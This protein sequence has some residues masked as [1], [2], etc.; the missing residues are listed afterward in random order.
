MV[1]CEVGRWSA[2][3]DSG[4]KRGLYRFAPLDRIRLGHARPRW[5]IGSS[6]APVRYDAASIAREQRGNK[7]GTAGFL[8]RAYDPYYLFPSGG[9]MD[10]NKMEEINVDDLQLRPEVSNSRLQRR[11]RLRDL[12][13]QQM[14]HIDKAVEQYDLNSY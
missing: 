12:L 1:L 10:M 4:G 2:F 3:I 11:A 9:D 7:A 5:E 14:P 8:G 13:N 6:H